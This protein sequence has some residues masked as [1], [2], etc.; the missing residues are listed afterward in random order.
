LHFT[1]SFFRGWDAFKTF[2]TIRRADFAAAMAT[3]ATAATQIVEN[4]K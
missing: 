4:Q 2:A 1:V 3:R